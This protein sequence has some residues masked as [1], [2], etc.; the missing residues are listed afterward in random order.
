MSGQYEI[1]IVIPCFNSQEYIEET[2]RSCLSQKVSDVEI[3]VVDD[4][5]SDNSLKLV[6]Q[7]SAKNLNIKIIEHEKN[8]GT[9][10]ARASGIRGASGK[11]IVFLDSDD[12]LSLE[13]TDIISRTSIE[14]GADFIF[15]GMKN[16][17][18]KIRLTKT[19]PKTPLIGEEILKEFI[20][21][22]AEPVWGIGGKAIKRSLLLKSLEVLSFVDK[23]FI[24]A[25]D[26]LLCFVSAA[27]ANTAVSINQNLYIYVENESSITQSDSSFKKRDEQID[28]ALHFFKQLSEITLIKQHLYFQEAVHKSIRVLKATKVLNKRFVIG[29]I[30]SYYQAWKLNP[31]KK[32]LLIIILYLVTLGKFKR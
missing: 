10:E 4:K 14:S 26:A 11:L 2:I 29:Y 12:K 28:V 23:K 6:Q 21:V 3:I 17:G 25:E 13:A 7:L 18:K 22:P 27:L 30:N 8:L 5:S 9:F 24:Y 1:S 16:S 19:L 32:Y 31:Q 15:F 20:C